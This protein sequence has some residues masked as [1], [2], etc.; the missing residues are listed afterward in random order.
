MDELNLRN[1]LESVILFMEIA[2]EIEEGKLIGEEKH[3]YVINKMKHKL[4]ELYESYKS[5]IETMIESVVFLSK[6]G[7]KINVNNISKNCASCF[8]F[9]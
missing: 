6:I 9:L 7:R 3:E 5:E 4:G 2:E 8:S 1:I